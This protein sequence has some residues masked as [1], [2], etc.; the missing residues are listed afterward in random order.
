MFAAARRCGCGVVVAMTLAFVVAIVM[1]VAMDIV[2]A[3]ADASVVVARLV[4]VVSD[5]PLAA[6]GVAVCGLSGGRLCS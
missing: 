1:A 2:M 6:V 4:S 3:T 5:V